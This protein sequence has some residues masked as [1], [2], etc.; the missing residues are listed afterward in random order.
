MDIYSATTKL[1]LDLPTVNE[2]D[3]MRSLIQRAASRQPRDWRLPVMACRA[4]GGEEHQ[5]IAGVAAIAGMQISIILIDDML[6]SDPRGDY[7]RLGS[8]VAT[9]L[10]AA[11][12]SAALEAI[13]QSDLCDER[14]IAAMNSVNEMTLTTAH[15]QHLDAQ[16]PSDESAY[17]YVTKLKSSPFFGAAL[18]IGALMGGGDAESAEGLKRI[19][20][21]YGEMIQIH[22][23]LKDTMAMPANPDWIEKRSPLP[24]L[25]AQSVDHPQREHFLELRDSIGEADSLEEAQTILIHCGAVSYCVDQLVQRH[26][27]A[28]QMIQ[29]ISLTHRD[30]VEEWIDS[31]IVPIQNLFESVGVNV[32]LQ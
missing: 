24:I 6:D 23:D 31:Q 8:A 2:W 25:F 5:A 18:H 1:L 11:F 20:H 16:N 27:L 9:N 4:V 12:Q 21:L 30:E 15:G 3:E 22:D 26:R 13:A 28:R 17:W 29:T 32:L 10:A 7:H 19:G 14:K